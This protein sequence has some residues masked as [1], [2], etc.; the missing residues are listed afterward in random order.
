[1][2]DKLPDTIQADVCNAWITGDHSPGAHPYFEPWTDGMLF[3][4]TYSASADT[5]LDELDIVVDDPQFLKIGIIYS[6]DPSEQADI[7]R[8]TAQGS[9]D[10]RRDQADAITKT[11]MADAPPIVI[12]RKINELINAGAPIIQPPTAAPTVQAPLPKAAPKAA[13]PPVGHQA[14]V[15]DQPSAS[16]HPQTSLKSLGAAIRQFRQ[17]L[18]THPR[19]SAHAQPPAKAPWP[20]PWPVTQPQLSLRGADVSG[21]NPVS[22]RPGDQ[23]SVRF[24]HGYNIVVPSS[25]IPQHL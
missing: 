21:V 8:L 25:L 7:V 24:S 17:P 9:K 23:A 19:N 15:T 11:T 2:Q 10:G 14:P 18:P 1:M 20:R 16:Q 22:S 5:L 13:L 6:W 12:V 3:I 4:Y